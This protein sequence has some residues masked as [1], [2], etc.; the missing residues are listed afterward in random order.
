M[1]ALTFL[2]PISNLCSIFILFLQ[3]QC[4][5]R[6]RQL[7]QFP[8]LETIVSAK[9]NHSFKGL[10]LQ[11]QQLGIISFKRLELWFQAFGTLVSNCKT[12]CFK[13]QK[14]Q[15]HTLMKSTTSKHIPNHKYKG[16]SIIAITVLSPTA[17]TSLTIYNLIVRMKSVTDD[18]Y[19]LLFNLQGVTAKRMQ[20]YKTLKYFVCSTIFRHRIIFCNFL[21]AKTFSHFLQ[22]I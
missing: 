8:R 5:F 13:V 20:S 15:L 7:N 3:F 12:N 2:N 14:R 10:K 1:L 17:V 22:N 4:Q 9:R 6:I 21:F 18:R 11:F 16:D 19:I